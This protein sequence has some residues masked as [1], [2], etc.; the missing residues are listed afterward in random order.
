MPATVLPLTAVGLEDAALVG[1]KAATLGALL[2]AGFPVPPGVCLAA[3]ALARALG[4]R[5]AALAELLAAHDLGDAAGAQAAADAVAGLLADLAVPEEVA[6]D[7]RR[8]LAGIGADDQPL[9]V[10]SSALAEDRADASFAGQYATLLGVRGGAGLLDAV[11][12]C[13]RG[14]FSANA[15][16]ARAAAGATGDFTGMAVLVQRIVDAECAGVCFSLDPLTAAEDGAG[17]RLLIDAAWGLGPGV[18]DGSVAVDTFWLLR[19]SLEV[20][21]RRVVEKAEQVALAPEGGV[22]RVAV[23]EERRRAPV[24]PERWLRRVGEFALAAEGLLLAHQDVEW[25]IA[26]ERLWVLQSRPVTALPPR[27]AAVPDFP[28][29][30]PEASDRRRGWF[31]ERPPSFGLPLPLIHDEAEAYIGAIHDHYYASGGE[32][33]FDRL[34]VNGWGYWGRRSTGLHDGDRRL[35]KA[36]ATD[37]AVRL[38]EAGRTLWD[39][40]SPQIEALTERLRSFDPANADDA[41]LAEHLDDAFGGLRLLW[42]WHAQ[43]WDGMKVAL[44]P[45]YAACVAVTG[46]PEEES[47]RVGAALLDGEEHALSRLIDGL[48]ALGAEA[49]RAP[50]VAALLATAPPDL[51]PQLAAL[52]AA[53]P[54][55]Q[56]LAAF[57][58]RHGH[59]VG[60]GYGSRA[61]LHWP[62]WREDP[63]RLYALIAPYLD[64]AR[65]APAA[66]R[67]RS[68]AARAARLEELCAACSDAEKV[69][70][71]RRLLPYARRAAT[72]LEEH[73]ELIDQRAVGLLRTA[74]IAAADR[75]VERGR[76][77]QRGDI[78]WLRRDE[79]TAALRAIPVPAEGA[80]AAD[81]AA[82][83]RERERLAALIAERKARHAVCAA[84]RPPLVLGV[85]DATLDKRPPLKDEL[86]DTTRTEPGRITGL[87]ASAGMRCGRARL[88][89]LDTML[90]DLAPGDILVAKNAGPQWTP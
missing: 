50:A 36:A 80:A 20:A 8:A 86:T 83:A 53:E 82:A 32:R 74:I 48:A 43:L 29:D 3:E 12:A 24:L 57:L 63:A 34:V 88:V 28:V 23:A 4:P 1:R 22:T 73:N 62:T 90:P 16:A 2:D 68:Q 46:L 78:F 79:I 19:D 44:E 27:L 56:A 15:L 39:H 35:R 75:L 38:R 33:Y 52:P 65:E 72:W 87:A 81:D 10:R 60:M 26:G 37:L 18:V 45:F 49:R 42:Q 25:A 6:A 85:P 14:F 13:W 58:V 69:A 89:A 59:R 31:L 76:I 84:L 9:A 77:A 30:W 41:A 66:A 7:L 70:E 17:P 11:V 64:P 40:L 71:L 51:E 21:D 47:Q 61:G 67:A 5:Q 54:F 55:R